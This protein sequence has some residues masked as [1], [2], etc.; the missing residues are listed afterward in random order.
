[1]SGKVCVIGLTGQSA[2]ISTE[3][4]P[5]A[6]ETVSC[7]ALFFEPGGKGHN[8]AVAAARYGASTHFISALGADANASECRMAL[9][10]EDIRTTLL[11]KDEPTAFAVIT[12]DKS[13]EN[14]VEVCAGASK[15]LTADD[16]RSE[17]VLNAIMDCSVLLVQNELDSTCLHEAIITAKRF[18]KTV[19]FNPAPANDISEDI[20]SLCDVITPNFGEAMELTGASDEEQILERFTEM[21]IRNAVVT[22]GSRGSLVISNG[23]CSF[24][25]AFHYGETV[26]TTGAGDTFSGTLAAALASGEDLLDAAQI[27][28]MA[29]GISVTRTGAAGSIPTR[30]EYHNIIDKFRR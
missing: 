30:D 23:G 22:L 16:M 9:M 7:S 15:K 18:G 3:H 24:I 19:V 25:G 5:Q 13:G 28:S 21:N 2:F 29:A 27:A 14:M 12:T 4:F 11:V 17:E 8:Q 26:D 20:L 6:G 1:M 10:R